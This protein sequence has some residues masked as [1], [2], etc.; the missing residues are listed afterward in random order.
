MIPLIQE[1]M[2]Q[3]LSDLPVNLRRTETARTANQATGSSTVSNNSG[4]PDTPEAHT[5][6]KTPY[7][8]M[9]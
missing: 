5:K 7:L 1:T 6:E 4:N 9:T 2:V 3:V 8:V